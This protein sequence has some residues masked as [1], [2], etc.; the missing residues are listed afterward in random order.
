MFK[1]VKSVLAHLVVIGTGAY[2]TIT[3]KSPFFYGAV[4]FTAIFLFSK[5]L[6]HTSAE[7]DIIRLYR[8][9]AAYEK[10]NKELVEQLSKYD[11]DAA[12]VPPVPHYFDDY[13]D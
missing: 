9:I 4:A 12:D 2:A 8:R 1:N 10:Q 6:E 5:F 7:E 3:I 13:F 11:K